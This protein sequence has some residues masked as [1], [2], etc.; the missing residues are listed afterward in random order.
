MGERERRENERW[1]NERD[2]RMRDGRTREMGEGVIRREKRNVMDQVPGQRTKRGQRRGKLP[3]RGRGGL[4]PGWWWSGEC[5]V[6]VPS[7]SSDRS[8]LEPGEWED[9]E[10]EGVG[11]GWG[12]GSKHEQ[13]MLPT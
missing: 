8:P 12:V 11:V 2:G 4:P 10:G 1:E 3:C 5:I 7:C 13:H 6:A 9:V